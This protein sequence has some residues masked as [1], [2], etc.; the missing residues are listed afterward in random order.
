MA[1]MQ[2][3]NSDAPAGPGANAAS[4]LIDDRIAELGDWRGETL[5]RLRAIIRAADPGIVEEWK[6]AVPVWSHGGIICTG[7]TY[8]HIV[9]LT[10][11]RG[12]AL[13]DPEGL[14][15]AS[16]TGSTRR[17][18]D[19]RAGAPVEAAALTALV[20]AAVALNSAK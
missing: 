8:K 18:I 15:N 1:T 4:R 6:W 12:A 3:D 5:S 19:F 14:F 9:K 7:E 2:D 13:P 10:F 16:L 11:A 17:A 20:R